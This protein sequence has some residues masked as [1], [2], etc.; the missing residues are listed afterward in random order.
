MGKIKGFMEYDRLKE[1]VIE[2]QERIS[3]YNEFTIAPK[4][5]SFRSKEPDVWIVEFLFAI[6]VVR[7][8]T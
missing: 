4:L 5:K 6:A 8:E 2:P 1:P 7:W 3:N